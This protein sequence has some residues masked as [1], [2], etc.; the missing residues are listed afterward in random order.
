[1][2]IGFVFGLY[3]MFLMAAGMAVEFIHRSV[4]LLHIQCEFLMINRELAGLGGSLTWAGFEHFS[5]KV[6]GFKQ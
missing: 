2:S 3:F 4:L 6:T 1:M 5:L